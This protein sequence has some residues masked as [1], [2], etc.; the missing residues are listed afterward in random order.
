M[1][2][3]YIVPLGDFGFSR[4]SQGLRLSLAYLAPP[5]LGG[6]SLSARR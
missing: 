1:V 6:A 3:G 4:E 2:P 5:G